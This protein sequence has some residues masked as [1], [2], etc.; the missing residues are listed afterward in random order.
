LT[1]YFYPDNT[2]TMGMAQLKNLN[3]ELQSPTLKLGFWEQFS[4]ADKDCW[5]STK[6]ILSTDMAIYSF[7]LIQH[8][9]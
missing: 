5:L 1:D 9:C 4:S 6:T 2:Y 3:L 7:L 8:V